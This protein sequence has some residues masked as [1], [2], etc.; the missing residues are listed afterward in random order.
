MAVVSNLCNVW[1]MWAL[2]YRIL[3][4]EGGE[5]RTSGML[6]KDAVQVIFFWIRYMGVAPPGSVKLWG[7]YIAGWPGGWWGCSCNMILRGIGNI[8]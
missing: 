8:R 4:R 6:Y 5:F 7:V 1:Q 3:D 2:M